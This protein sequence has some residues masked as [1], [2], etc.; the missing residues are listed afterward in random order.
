MPEESN[1]PTPRPP[2][3]AGPLV[4]GIIIGALVVAVLAVIGKGRQR[5]T[6]APVEPALKFNDSEH[7]KTDPKLIA[8]KETQSIETGMDQPRAIALG[9][10]KLYVAG[11]RLVRA[12]TL[13]GCAQKKTAVGS[14]AY[15]IAVAPDGR[16]IVGL[17]DHIEVWD[18]KGK[19]L[20][21]W[22]SLGKDAHLTSL[23]ARGEY[24]WA[25]DAGNRVALQY[26]AKG[27]IVARFG[28][29]N[30]ARNHPGLVMPSPHLDVHVDA[31]GEVWL[32]NPGRHRLEAYA[33]NSELSRKWGTPSPAIDGFCGCCNPTDFAFLPDGRF[34]T[35][36]KGIPRVKVYAAN[37]AFQHVVA[38]CESF[39]GD[40]ISLDLAVSK[41][42]RI[43][44]LDPEK[45]TVRVF[46]PKENVKP[47]SSQSAQRPSEGIKP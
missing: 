32:N 5:R 42:G 37:G 11:D 28:E 36:E 18:A 19:R 7:R 14:G 27:K 40:N 31:Q 8:W 16:L 30:P 46:E 29:K 41:D 26:D 15:C 9:K 13:D 2:K 22:D 17:K 6:P 1:S 39:E 38:G 45:K 47:Q 3:K 43:Y 25:G 20:A 24:V 10:D 12:F 33:E 35:A 4:I 23:F 34:V 44:V 21:Q